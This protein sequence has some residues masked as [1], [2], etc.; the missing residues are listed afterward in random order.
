MTQG[1]A[2]RS[3][4]TSGCVDD[5]RCSSMRLASAGWSILVMRMRPNV[6]SSA[7]SR[8]DAEE[9]VE[10]LTEAV[11]SRS[12]ASRPPWPP[13]PS[14]PSVVS[15]GPFESEPGQ[16]GTYGV[17]G[18]QR[19]GCAAPSPAR[20]RSSVG[21]LRAVIRPRRRRP[22]CAR[23]SDGPRASS[24]AAP[25]LVH[26]HPPAD[27]AAGSSPSATRRSRSAWTSSATS[28]PNGL[29]PNRRIP[30]R[31]RPPRPASR[32]T[33]SMLPM[34]AIRSGRPV[35]PFSSSSANPTAR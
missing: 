2:I 14:P 25:G 15:D 17:E 8:H 32:P 6:V 35:I 21:A 12:R 11:A 23:S 16:P 28:R 30:G 29:K 5:H 26:G 33:R 18:A 3:S 19:E 9:D 1:P 22:P 27:V 13:R 31:P 10:R 34:Q 20:C 4:R 7:S 24:R